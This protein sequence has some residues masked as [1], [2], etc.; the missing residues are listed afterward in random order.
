[1]G[2]WGTGLYANDTAADLRDDLRLAVRAPWDGEHLVQWVQGA[3]PGSADPTDTDYLDLRLALADLLW[4]YGIDHPETIDVARRIIDDGT[5][6]AGKRALGMSEPDLRRRAKVLEGLAHRL[7]TSNPAARPRRI[8]ERPEP[9]AL[10]AGDCLAYPLSQGELRNPYVGS[11][12]QARYFS[13]H[14]WKPDGW[15]AAF[16][17]SRFRKYEVFAR[18]GVAVLATDPAVKVSMADVPGLSIVQ[19]RVHGG[20]P[21]RLIRGVAA[22]RQHLR[23]MQV[24]VIGRLPVDVERVASALGPDD[25]QVAGH[26]TDHS[27]ANIGVMKAPQLRLMV[28]GHDP[29]GRFLVRPDR[30]GSPCAA[31]SSSQTRC[32]GAPAS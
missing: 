20:P 24:E 32:S 3:Y 9:W 27:L 11:R 30:S 15:G 8:L 14:P 22:S 4:T 7:A 23:R 2:T 18:Y 29:I 19:Q 1:M 13:I 31:A 17:L 6:L 16:V 12:D 28:P 26:G 5:D 10:D 21:L 25:P